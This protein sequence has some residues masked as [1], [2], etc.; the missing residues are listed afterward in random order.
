MGK[1][2]EVWC[3]ARIIARNRAVSC[4]TDTPAEAAYR[5]RA[6]DAPEAGERPILG[7]DNAP[8]RETRMIRIVSSI[9]MVAAV[10]AAP[11][12]SEGIVGDL[13]CTSIDRALSERLRGL[14]PQQANAAPREVNLALARMAAARFDCKHGHIDRGLGRYAEADSALQALEE[15]AA[16]KLAPEREPASGDSAGP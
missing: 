14:H 9:A 4:L 12:S 1:L 2:L 7:A 8:S 13:R 6:G 10:N 16:A 11:V 15:K 3:D 5:Y